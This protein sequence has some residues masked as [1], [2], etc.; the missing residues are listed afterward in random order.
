MSASDVAQLS[1]PSV[2]DNLAAVGARIRAAAEAAGRDPGAVALVAVG[3]KQPSER[4]VA[5]LAG[6]HRLFGE[7]RV[8][9][10]AGK[11]PALK[12]DYPDLVLHLIGPLQTNKAAEAVALFDVIETLDRPKLA[13]ALAKEMA[14]SG[15][16][17]RLYVQVNTGEE[18]QKAGVA[19][20]EADALVSYAR[21]EL[22]LPVVGLMCIPPVDDEP[23]PHFAF[24]REIARRNGLEVL[25]MGMSADFE[26]AIRFG[27][28]HVRVGTA[29]FGPRPQA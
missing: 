10:A 5:A 11:F 25:S 6:G 29:V 23:A 14:K 13:R 16:R 12:A 17:P 21:D 18:P 26:T 15:R 9:E 20:T 24:L 28:T 7:N 27:A 8:Q 4:L 3:K 1:F 22:G 19:P 2:A